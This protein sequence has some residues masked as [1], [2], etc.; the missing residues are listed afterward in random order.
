MARVLYGLYFNDQ[1]PMTRAEIAAAYELPIEAVDEA[2][3]YCETDP[4][5]VRTD[6]EMEE[7]SVRDMVQ[8]NPQYVHPAMTNP[9]KRSA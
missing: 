5:E 8:K 9:P 3:A 4:P 7:A 2:I 6:W 1:E